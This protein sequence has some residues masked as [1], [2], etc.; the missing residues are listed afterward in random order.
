M[1][2]DDCDQDNAKHCVFVF[3]VAVF[4]KI[5]RVPEERTVVTV[6]HVARLHL[7]SH[8]NKIR[9]LFWAILTCWYKKNDGAVQDTSL[10]PARDLFYVV[11]CKVSGVNKNRIMHPTLKVL[12]HSTG[13]VLWKF[14]E[15]I[16][17]SIYLFSIFLY[18]SSSPF[19]YFL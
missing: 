2:R 16:V 11:N 3:Y 8:W 7:C 14:V 12:R 4:F 5:N 15:F 6:P 13:E 10:S 17:F 1:T 19:V 18:F 9:P